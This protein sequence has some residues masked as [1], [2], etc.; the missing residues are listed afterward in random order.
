MILNLKKIL[1]NTK[2]EEKVEAKKDKED[3][4]EEMM[5]KDM[6]SKGADTKLLDK[7]VADAKA[8]ASVV[9]VV[10]PAAKE[11]DKVQTLRQEI[12]NALKAKVSKNSKSGVK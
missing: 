7:A 9:P 4:E 5:D 6:A 2:A 11:D 10:D 8:T 3:D 12:A 1:E